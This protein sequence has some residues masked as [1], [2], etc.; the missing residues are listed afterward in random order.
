MELCTCGAITN[1]KFISLSQSRPWPNSSTL[2][3]N[4][5]LSRANPGRIY[6]IN[7]SLRAS[8]SE[9]TSSQY[10]VE[11]SITTNG[12]PVTGGY[13]AAEKNLN[14]DETVEKDGIEDTPTDEQKQAFEFLDKLDVKLDPEDTPSV[15][16]L[17]GGSL[18]AVWIAIVLVGAIDSIPLFPKLMEVVGLGYT[19]W[20]SSR[21]L[22]FKKNREELVVKIDEIK[23]QVLGSSENV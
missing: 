12:E 4:L 21:Y 1:P 22:L 2:S 18:I 6:L 7:S 13:Q 16:L 23:Q 14:V 5:S 3:R 11:G 10:I 17:G 20:F 9:E 8:S 15:L 19:L